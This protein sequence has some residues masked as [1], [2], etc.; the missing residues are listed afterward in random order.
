ML[1]VRPATDA[2]L[3]P[4]Y[5]LILRSDDGLTSLKITR[6]QLQDRLESSSFAFRRHS[7]KPSGL[8]Y[9][10]VMEDLET[11]QVVQRALPPQRCRMSTPLSSRALTRRVPSV[12]VN[13]LPFAVMF[14]MIYSLF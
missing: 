8:P 9:V 6:E 13:V 7:Q 14:A 4:L 3:D 12:T 11:R 1:R 5:A 2:D 10:F